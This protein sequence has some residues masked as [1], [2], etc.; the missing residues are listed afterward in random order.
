M[1]KKSKQHGHIIELNSEGE[2]PKQIQLLPA[3]DVHGRDGRWWLNNKPERILEAFAIYAGPLSI[4]YEHANDLVVGEPIPSAGWISAIHNID[5]Q[6]WGDVDWTPR[7]KQMIEDKEYRFV[8]PVFYSDDSNVIIEII[9]AGLTNRPNL[10][11]AA[12][13]KQQDSNLIL[14]NKMNP[15]QRKQLCKVLGLTDDATDESIVTAAESLKSDKEKALNKASSFDANKVVP[16]ADYQQVRGD[17]DKALNKISEFETA[18]AEAV[19][20]EAIKNRKIAPSS[21]DYHLNAC[22]T[23]GG[24]EAFKKMV[25]SSPAI[26]DDQ[27]DLNGDPENK[28]PELNKD[29]RKILEGLGVDVTDEKILA[30]I[31]D[32]S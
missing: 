9:G 28:Q 22:K 17:L 8:S 27:N 4:D 14:E 23:E 19:V 7:A 10:V 24:L 32:V 6:I 13:N 12:L 11:M 29:Q 25:A 2:A 31:K 3:G 30:D 21:K 16:I 20:D 18:G 15:E 26:I 5:G 1:S